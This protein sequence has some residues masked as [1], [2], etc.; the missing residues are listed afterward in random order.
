MTTIWFHVKTIKILKKQNG[1][2]MVNKWAKK[3]WKIKFNKKYYFQMIRFEDSS[4]I[5]VINDAVLL[6]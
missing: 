6:F 4:F 2:F 1:F 5:K 3:F